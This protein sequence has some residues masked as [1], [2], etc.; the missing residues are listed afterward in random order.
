LG[1]LALGHGIVFGGKEGRVGG[2][3]GGAGRPAI[4]YRMYTYRAGVEG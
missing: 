4:V 1:F 2:E 3:G